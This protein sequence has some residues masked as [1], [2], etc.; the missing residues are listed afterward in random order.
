[1]RIM[2]YELRSTYVIIG[3]L[4]AVLLLRTCA[5]TSAQVPSPAPKPEVVL[6]RDTVY[7]QAMNNDSRRRPV[8][9]ERKT[10]VY[11]RDTV[12]LQAVNNEQLPMDNDGQPA[13]T[14]A[15]AAPSFAEGPA[16][17]SGSL[18]PAVADT[19]AAPSSGWSRWE[20]SFHAGAGVQQL[21]AGAAGCSMEEGG[22]SPTFGVDFT[23]YFARRWG[24][25]LGADVSFYNVRLIASGAAL[26]DASRVVTRHDETLRATYVGIPL[27]LH[28]RVPVWRRHAFHAA[29][30]GRF[31]FAV[32]DSYR[33]DGVRQA[34]TAGSVAEPFTHSGKASFLPGVSLLAEAGMRWS[35]DKHW[36]IYTG[37]YAGYGL[38]DVL[39]DA[40]PDALTQEPGTGSL[41]NQY[42]KQGQPYVEDIRLLQ[43]GV[44]LKLSYEL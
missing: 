2:T 34:I 35:L 13:D 26:E 27:L 7:L 39:P 11:L 9:R 31:D 30:G 28:F 41:L 42:N 15:A 19:V 17:P 29:A 43:V 22:L 32:Y 23:R 12:Y 38:S 5:G 20:A 36:G 21:L 16:E 1:M 33:V 44:K 8:V 10:V 24:V 6:L 40:S 18:L 37:A 3:A 14:V 4:L 25:S